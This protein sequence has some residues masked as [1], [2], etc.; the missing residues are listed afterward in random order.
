M[1]DLL[2]E[3]EL[4]R[5]A[6]ILMNQILEIIE[7]ITKDKFDAKDAMEFKR[8]TVNKAYVLRPSFNSMFS[9]AK[10]IF[11]VDHAFL[12][13]INHIEEI[14]EINPTSFNTSEYLAAYERIKVGLSE[15]V[16]VLKSFIRIYMPPK[17][18]EQI[19]FK[20]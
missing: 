7:D 11:A 20:A 2:T 19:G 15:L 9:R 8:Q 3:E 1:K 12:K 16:G 13:A 10:E 17:E 5:T 6:F 14:K 18:K 4:A